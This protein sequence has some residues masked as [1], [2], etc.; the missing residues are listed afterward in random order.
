M[1]ENRREYSGITPGHGSGILISKTRRHRAFSASQTTNPINISLLEWGEEDPFNSKFGNSLGALTFANPKA[2]FHFIENAILGEDI[3][4]TEL[5]KRYYKAPAT[6]PNDSQNDWS[7]A[8]AC[9]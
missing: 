4:I 1:K 7:P 2:V 6:R 9:N 8:A 5:I 3:K